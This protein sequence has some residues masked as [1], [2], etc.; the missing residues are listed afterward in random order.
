MELIDSGVLA[1]ESQSFLCVSSQ[2]GEYAWDVLYVAVPKQSL[3]FCSA[4]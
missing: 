2:S 4:L 1:S 3:D